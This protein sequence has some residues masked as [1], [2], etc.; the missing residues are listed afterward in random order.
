MCLAAPYRAPH[1]KQG[2]AEKL[3]RAKQEIARGGLRGV[4]GPVCRHKKQVEHKIVPLARSRYGPRMGDA[5][6]IER[7]FQLAQE[8]GSIDEL[9]RKLTREGYTNVAAHLDGRHI[10]SQIL[11]LLNQKQGHR[12]QSARSGTTGGTLT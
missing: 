7:A 5:T 1:Q 12:F 8:C 9:R 3:R 6:V 10:R 4:K 2:P 11:P